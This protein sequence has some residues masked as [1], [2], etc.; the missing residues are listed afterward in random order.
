MAEYQTL[1]GHRDLK[2]YQLAY[3]LAMDIF[4]ASQSFPNE[5]NI[6]SQIRSAAL[7]EV[8]PPISQKDSVNDSIPKCF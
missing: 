8:L 1:K 2:V 6:P 5:E 4:R 7:P 3:K